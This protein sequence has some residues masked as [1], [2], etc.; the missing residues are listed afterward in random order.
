MA[1]LLTWSTLLGGVIGTLLYVNRVVEHPAKLVQR[2][3]QNLLAYDF[4][5]PKIYRN[6]FVLAIDLLSKITDWLDRYV[7]DGLVNLVGVASLFSGETLKYGNTGRLQ[8]Y[9]LTIALGVALLAMVMTWQY[10]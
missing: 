5:T 8:F 4:Y 3:L 10:L 9:V 6:T 7:V 1:L 2:P